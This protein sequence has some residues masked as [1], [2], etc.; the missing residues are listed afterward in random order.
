M[1][2]NIPEGE[3]HF[4]YIRGYS[5]HFILETWQEG[6]AFLT[7]PKLFSGHP[8][9]MF[10]LIIIWTQIKIT[11]EDRWQTLR[12]HRNRRRHQPQF[13][14]PHPLHFSITQAPPQP[15]TSISQSALWTLPPPLFTATD[16]E[17]GGGFLTA[18]GGGGKFY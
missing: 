5:R 8:K 14:P 1:N 7:Q 13:H 11:I 12:G 10:S 2:P 3:C 17:K 18:G 4:F 9:I 6:V 16:W 15:V